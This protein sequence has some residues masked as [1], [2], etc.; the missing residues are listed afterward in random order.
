MEDASP[1]LRR[2]PRSEEQDREARENLQR[3]IEQAAEK[4]GVPVAAVAAVKEREASERP[5][6]ILFEPITEGPF[7]R[8]ELRGSQLVVILNTAH[9]FFTEVY[10]PL[11]GFEGSRVRVGLELLLFVLGMSETEAMKERRDWYRTERGD[12]SGKLSTVLTR[13]EGQLADL[14]ERDED[15]GA[16]EA[17][18]E[19]ASPGRGIGS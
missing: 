13:L 11:A 18:D 3:D 16:E 6:K 10:A 4:A 1:I 12:W 9:P 8:P 7:Y 15:A 14:V 19:S 17:G 2:R 5:F